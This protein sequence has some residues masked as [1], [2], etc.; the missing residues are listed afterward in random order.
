MAFSIKVDLNLPDPATYRKIVILHIDAEQPA[1]AGVIAS[2]KNKAH[3]NM[4][5]ANPY[6]RSEFQIP[7]QE[8]QDHNFDTGG[9]VFAQTYQILKAR[10]EYKS[11]KKV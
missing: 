2:Y 6:A 5:N 8:L 7:P 11:A 10:P 9:D 1:V 4:K 3:R